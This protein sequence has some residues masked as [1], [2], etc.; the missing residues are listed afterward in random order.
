MTI[1]PDCGSDSEPPVVQR[2][3]PPTQLSL[4]SQSMMDQQVFLVKWLINTFI[5]FFVCFHVLRVLNANFRLLM[6]YSI[7]K[8]T[9]VMKMHIFVAVQSIL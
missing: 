3:D 8:K 5:F 1:A 4:L 2:P 9:S 6:N 7:Q